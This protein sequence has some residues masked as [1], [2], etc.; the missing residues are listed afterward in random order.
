MTVPDLLGTGHLEMSA[1]RLFCLCENSTN[2][3]EMVDSYVQALTVASSGMLLFALLVLVGQCCF[4]CGFEDG[5]RYY[6]PTLL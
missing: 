1:K 4:C 2:Y 3:L 5:S 6:D